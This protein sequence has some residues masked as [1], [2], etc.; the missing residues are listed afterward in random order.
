MRKVSISLA[1][2]ILFLGL[3]LL[4]SLGGDNDQPSYITVDGRSLDAR[5]V[6]AA[7]L[8]IAGALVTTAFVA[9]RRTRRLD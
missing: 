1:A 6:A 4:A 9:W 5:I 2:A 3:A 8:G 7:C